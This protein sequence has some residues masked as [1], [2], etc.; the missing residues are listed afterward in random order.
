MAVYRLDSTLKQSSQKDRAGAAQKSLT[1]TPM[2]CSVALR[3]QAVP[4]DL[5]VLNLAF[6]LR[7]QLKLLESAQ[8]I[9]NG[10]FTSDML[11]GPLLGRSRLHSCC[12]A[13]AGRD[14]QQLLLRRVLIHAKA[15]L[16]ALQPRLVGIISLMGFGESGGRAYPINSIL[17]HRARFGLVRYHAL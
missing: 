11:R 17:I 5:R 6:C 13:S 9:S 4:A 1:R 12:S 14:Q 10:R 16:S 7:P 3:A 8:H 2:H 15:S